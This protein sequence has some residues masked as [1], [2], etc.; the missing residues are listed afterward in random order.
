[1]PTPVGPAPRDPNDPDL[2]EEWHES[3]EAVPRSRFGWPVRI[4]AILVV[5]TLALLI[6]LG[7]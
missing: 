4:L 2:W 5:V 3:D 1:M 6:I 7:G